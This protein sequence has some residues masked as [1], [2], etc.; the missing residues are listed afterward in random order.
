MKTKKTI[1]RIFFT[2]KISLKTFVVFYAFFFL[3]LFQSQMYFMYI[4]LKR[5]SISFPL[6]LCLQSIKF[7]FF[8]QLN[9]D[10]ITCITNCEVNSI[11]IVL[12]NFLFCFSRFYSI[13]IS[14]TKATTKL[15]YSFNQLIYML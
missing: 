14:K 6:N 2:S 13:V 12:H 4:T 1:F 8:S 5:W 11:S 9:T 7:V 15:H 3:A 10:L